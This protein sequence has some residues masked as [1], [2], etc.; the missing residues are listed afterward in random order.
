MGEKF[1]VPQPL[2]SE[3]RR[4][5][6]AQTKSQLEQKLQNLIAELYEIFDPREIQVFIDLYKYFVPSEGGGRNCCLCHSRS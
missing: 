3:D 5:R 6:D 2:F 4:L 1:T